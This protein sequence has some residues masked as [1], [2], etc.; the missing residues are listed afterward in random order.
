MTSNFPEHT[1]AN[2]FFHSGHGQQGRP[3]MGSWATYGL[4][5]HNRNLPSYVVLNGGRIPSGGLDNFS[6]GF[7]PASFQGSLLNA[8]GTALANIA[9][10]ETQGSVQQIKRDLARKLNLELLRRSGPVDALESAIA[11][12]ELAARMQ[13]AAPEVTDL[14]GESKATHRLYGLDRPDKRQAKF[15]RMCLLGRRLIERGAVSYT[16]LTLPTILLV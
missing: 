14:A 1:G 12:A 4:G 9:P 2:Y 11:N 10:N 3:S 13:T 8:Q 16:H 5:T 6:N 7:L 15:S